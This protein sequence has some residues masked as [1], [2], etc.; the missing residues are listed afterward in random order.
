M[1]SLIP[2][3]LENL[4]ADERARRVSEFVAKRHDPPN[5]EIAALETE[6]AELEK[7]YDMPSDTMRSEYAAGRVREN[8]DI[9]RWLMLL[10]V[11]DSLVTR[12]R[13]AS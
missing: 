2:A 11:R 8:A 4:S 9:C 12:G 7:S 5:G 3:E 1:A 10:R 6:L 13:S